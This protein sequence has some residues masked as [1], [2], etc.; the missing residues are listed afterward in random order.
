VINSEVSNVQLPCISVFGHNAR[1]RSA[2]SYYVMMPSNDEFVCIRYYFTK[3]DRP[4]VDPV[5]WPTTP[6]SKQWIE[7]FPV[8]AKVFFPE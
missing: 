8:L 2:Y 7:R 1:Q 6:N 3:V 4:V 5:R